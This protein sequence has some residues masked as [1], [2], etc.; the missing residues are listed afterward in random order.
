MAFNQKGIK[1]IIKDFLEGRGYRQAKNVFN[2][3]NV[4]L[5]IGDK[6]FIINFAEVSDSPVRTLSEDTIQI[7][8]EVVILWKTSNQLNTRQNELFD[9]E[10]IIIPLIRDDLDNSQLVK[11]SQFLTKTH[12]LGLAGHQFIMTT[13]IFQI[14]SN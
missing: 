11:V 5:S 8:A 10:D 13:M 9:E 3:D 12:E 7:R 14:E 2:L 1:N 4:P 6:T